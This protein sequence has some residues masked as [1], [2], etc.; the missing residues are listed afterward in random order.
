MIYFW[1]ILAYAFLSYCTGKVFVNLN[2]R[3]FDTEFIAT[4]SIL[5][6]ITIVIYLI[7]CFVQMVLTI[8]DYVGRASSYLRQGE[9]WGI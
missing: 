7:V 4:V 9:G 1:G 6:P 3:P 5:W 8:F 2:R